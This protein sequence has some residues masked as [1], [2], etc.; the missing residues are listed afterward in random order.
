[1]RWNYILSKS[2]KSCQKRIQMMSLANRY[3]PLLGR[4]TCFVLI[5]ASFVHM[6]TDT[7]SHDDAKVFDTAV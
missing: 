7:L 4:K 5:I 3:T 1:M 2:H 6:N